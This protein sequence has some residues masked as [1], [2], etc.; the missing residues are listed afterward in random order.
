[1]THLTWISIDSLIE[2]SKQFFHTQICK[3]IL[4]FPAFLLNDFSFSSCFWS[5]AMIFISC[6]ICLFIQLHSSCLESHIFLH[7]RYSIFSSLYFYFFCQR[8]PFFRIY[9]L[10]LVFKGLFCFSISLFCFF[11]WHE[12]CLFSRW[13]PPPIPDFV[14]PPSLLVTLHSGK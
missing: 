9:S 2:G 7:V 13:Y 5:W 1:M 10:F 12:S 11:L 14:R 4:E 8:R 6:S 3:F